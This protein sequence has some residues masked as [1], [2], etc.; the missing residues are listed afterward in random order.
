MGADS[1]HEVNTHSGPGPD[2]AAEVHG[3]VRHDNGYNIMEMVSE[4]RALRARIIKLWTNQNRLLSDEDVVDLTR[5]NE[6]ID[7]ALSESVAKFS[8]KVDQSKDLLLGVLGHD[9]RN[10]LAT[11]HMSRSS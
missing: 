10:P 7:Q 11:I 4:Y 9:I 5:F 8:E 6:S 3:T 1:A 2:T